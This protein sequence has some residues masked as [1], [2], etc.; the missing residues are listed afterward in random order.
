LLETSLKTIA[1]FGAAI[2][3]RYDALRNEVYQSLGYG[4]RRLGPTERMIIEI[5]RSLLE[6]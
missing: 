5:I 2:A 4:K 3:T 1:T 6:N